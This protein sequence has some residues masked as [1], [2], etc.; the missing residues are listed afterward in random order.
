MRT[1]GRVLCAPLSARAVDVD[2]C[3]HPAGT[4][5]GVSPGTYQL[6][7][8]GTSAPSSAGDILA[9][10][11]ANS[12][13]AG[14]VF[15]VVSE[16]SGSSGRGSSSTALFGASLTGYTYLEYTAKSPATTRLGTNEAAKK[17]QY[18]LAV[19][20]SAPDVV[21]ECRGPARLEK[22]EPLRFQ[23]PVELSLAQP[24]AKV[25]AAKKENPLGMWYSI[26][27]K[28]NQKWRTNRGLSVFGSVE[29]AEPV[30]AEWIR[31]ASIDD[32]AP[33]REALQRLIQPLGQIATYEA[34]VRNCWQ[35]LVLARAV[36]R[37]TV[38]GDCE[39]MALAAYTVL[40]NIK[41]GRGRSSLPAGLRKIRWGRVRPFLCAGWFCRTASSREA[42]MWAGLCDG[43]RWYFVE[44]VTAG[45]Y[46]R[47]VDDSYIAVRVFFEDSAGWVTTKGGSLFPRATGGTDYAVI[48]DSRRGGPSTYRVQSSLFGATTQ[49]PPSLPLAVAPVETRARARDWVAEPPAALRS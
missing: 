11:V 18:S 6:C 25:V 19:P 27:L 10:P 30:V 23:K 1:K 29:L 14:L 4:W 7:V 12:V 37:T 47:L 13:P 26:I 34:E 28:G 15:E 45:S 48:K 43:D 3:S 39:D 16:D 31:R 36:G 42:H 38:S 20:V 24:P 49:D 33:P 46:E 40:Q 35:N 9:R 41:A 44:S 32:D 21:V 2:G 5:F 8:W 17:C 22:V